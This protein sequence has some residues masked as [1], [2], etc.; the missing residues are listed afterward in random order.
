MIKIHRRIDEILGEWILDLKF[1]GIK[2][3]FLKIKM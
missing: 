2:P 3:D 1:M